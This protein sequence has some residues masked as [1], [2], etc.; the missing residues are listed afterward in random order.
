MINLMKNKNR[1]ESD[2]FLIN[3]NNI[4]Y[5]HNEDENSKNKFFDSQDEMKNSVLNNNISRYCEKLTKKYKS[6]EN[7]N[8]KKEIESYM[9]FKDDNSSLKFIYEF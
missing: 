4:K 5:I 6:N 2:S 3:I 7:K 9:N 1:E 8:E